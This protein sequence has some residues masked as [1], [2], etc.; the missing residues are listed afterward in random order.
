METI[1]KVID[2]GHLTK[3]QLIEKYEWQINNLVNPKT[4]LFE[5]TTSMAD[6][7]GKHPVEFNRMLRDAGILKPVYRVGKKG[8]KEIDIVGWKITEEHRRYLLAN[9]L[10]M[11][12]RETRDAVYWNQSKITHIIMY[13]NIY[14]KKNFMPQLKIK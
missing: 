2:A 14:L 9:A 4:Y 8:N 3:E 7:L 10:A 6:R 12:A 1:E 5:T 11:E 13:I